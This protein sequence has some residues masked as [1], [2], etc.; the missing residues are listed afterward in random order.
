MKVSSEHR[1]TESGVPSSVTRSTQLVL[2]APPTTIECRHKYKYKG[3][4]SVQVQIYYWNKKTYV[5][6][7]KE[8]KKTRMNV[9]A[10]SQPARH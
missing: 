2:P 10:I 5:K 8:M 3:G 6:N 7:I 9:V 4:L 1:T